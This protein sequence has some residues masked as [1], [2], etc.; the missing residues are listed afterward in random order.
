M[1]GTLEKAM[2]ATTLA[3]SITGG[4]QP[5]ADRLLP[6]LHP[7]LQNMTTYSADVYPVL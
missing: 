7:P 5:R 6:L 4:M 1:N 3:A 2:V